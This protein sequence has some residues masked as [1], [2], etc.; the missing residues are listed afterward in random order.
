LCRDELKDTGRT[1][2][3]RYDGR[4][5]EYQANMAMSALL[6]PRPLVQQVIAPFLQTD[7]FVPSLAREARS[8]VVLRLAEVFDVNPA[9]A[10]IRLNEIFPLAEVNQL[11]L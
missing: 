11:S 2:T 10:R 8:E 5:W 9:A 4:W 7:R 3:A 6:M 1:G